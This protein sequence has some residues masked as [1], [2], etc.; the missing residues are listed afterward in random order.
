M[1]LLVLFINKKPYKEKQRHNPATDMDSR[2]TKR[3][4]TRNAFLKSKSEYKIFQLV[5]RKCVIKTVWSYEEN[6]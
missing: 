4:R 2:K 6:G 5:A 1:T 3:G